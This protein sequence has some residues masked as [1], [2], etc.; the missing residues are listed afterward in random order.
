MTSVE[1][2]SIQHRILLSQPSL[3]RIHE[4]IMGCLQRADK[5]AAFK[6]KLARQPLQEGFFFQ[7]GREF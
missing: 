6:K 1:V 2:L 7:P 3:Q 5:T 4:E